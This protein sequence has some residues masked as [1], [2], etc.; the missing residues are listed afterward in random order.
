MKTNIKTSRKPQGAKNETPDIC[1]KVH[2]SQTEVLVAACDTELVGTTICD[3]DIEFHVSEVF[4]VDLAGSKDLL[5]E[6]L[7]VAT[8]ANLVGNRSVECGIAAGLVD[9]KNVLMIG[10]VPHAQFA[11]M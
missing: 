8:I 7:K 5:I 4:Y 9:R 3:G 10:D 1:I 11:V 6:H 2:T